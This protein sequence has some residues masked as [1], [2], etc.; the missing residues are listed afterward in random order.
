MDEADYAGRIAIIDHGAIV[1]LDTPDAL[2]RSVGEDTV[3]LST[4][5]DATAER[6]LRA[7]GR[8]VRRQEGGVTVYTA[9]GES[10]VARL[11]EVAGVPVHNVHVRRPTLDDVFLHYTGRQIREA[12]AEGMRSG[13]ARAWHAR[14]R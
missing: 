7:S 2:R 13:R 4:A 9:D 3:E 5:D 14:R 6:R 12:H 8:E 11:I 1:A 10:Q